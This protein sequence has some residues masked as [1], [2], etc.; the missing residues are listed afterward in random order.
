MDKK[1]TKHFEEK[2]TAELAELKT[3]LESV[4][5]KNP[6]NPSDWQAMPEKMDTLTADETEIADSLEAFEGNTAILKQLEIRYNEVKAALA[7][8]GAGTYGRCEKGGEVI[9]TE[10]LEAN[11]AATTCKAHMR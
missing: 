4:G 7:R 2:L 10:R 6:D 1:I 9:E 11:P 8:V 3:E 5:R